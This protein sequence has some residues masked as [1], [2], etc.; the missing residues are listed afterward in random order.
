MIILRDVREN[1][2]LTEM[3]IGSK[4][5][6]KITVK[7]AYASTLNRI[8]NSHGTICRKQKREDKD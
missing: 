7:R 5:G 1:M 6:M 4:I 8:E 2:V 3:K